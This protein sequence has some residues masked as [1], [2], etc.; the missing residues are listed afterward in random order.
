MQQS[1]FDRMADDSGEVQE[2]EMELEE[3]DQGTT[4]QATPTP[5]ASKGAAEK[6]KQVTGC[7]H[8]QILLLESTIER[9]GKGSL[10]ETLPQI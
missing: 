7:L 6:E 1:K 8:V 10:A 9:S 5:E 2:I 3:Q 4:E